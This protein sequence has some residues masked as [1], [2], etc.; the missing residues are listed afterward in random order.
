MSE[1]QPC[2]SRELKLL[3]LF[4]LPLLFL[5]FVSATS[6][7]QLV[8]PVT[9]ALPLSQ[10]QS[11]EEEEFIKPGRPGT[12]NPAEIHKTGV[13]QVEIG[14]DANFRAEEFRAEH[15]LPLTLRY[16]AA[17]RLLFELNL[18][19]VKSQTDE[20]G[21]RMTGVGD[22]RLG[23]QIVAL[24]NTNKHPAM[25]FA[26]YV[27]LPS[28]S[29]RKG[30]GTGRFDHK[31]LY[32]MSTKFGEV[33]MDFNAG[34]LIVGREDAPGWVTG[35]QG[36]ISFSG[37]FKNGFGL[38]GELFGQSKDDVQPRGI[39]ALGGMT[40][41]ANRRLIFDAGMRFGLNSDAPRIGV[42]TGV[43]FGAADLLKDK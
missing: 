38:I 9:D 7:Q 41:K 12:A 17:S 5:F 10:A 28:A 29:Q 14:Y 34:Y 37:S 25:A 8:I 18:D 2:A 40:Y 19:A 43:T 23:L 24:K 20:T 31:I 26:Y 16:A 27:K 22:T 21:E 3:Q 39:Y 6:A 1:H 36:A 42:F 15:T 35:G 13:L 32:L 30:L 33:D 4:L 11:T